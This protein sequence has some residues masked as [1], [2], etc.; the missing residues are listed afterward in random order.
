[1]RVSNPVM[2]RVALFAALLVCAGLLVLLPA[3]AQAVQITYIP[4]IQYI[5]PD[6]GSRA[7]GTEIT[8][9]GSGFARNGVEGTYVQPKECA[10]PL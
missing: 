3:P 9:F 6:R 4:T 8:I 5:T 1:M 2:P 10:G 7:G